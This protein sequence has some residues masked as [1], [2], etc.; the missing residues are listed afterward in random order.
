MK[1]II[2]CDSFKGTLSSNEANLII[3]DAV[4]S[5]LEN[6]KI[7]TIPYSD[8]GEGFLDSIKSVYPT[9]KTIRVNV[10]GSYLEEKNVEY[11]IHDG[12]AFIEIAKVCG[13]YN[14]KVDTNPLYTTTFG[15][16]EVILDALNKGINDFHIGLGGSNT[17]DAGLGMIAALGVRFINNSNIDIIPTGKD[18]IDI[19]SID[20][21]NLININ[22]DFHIYSDVN[23]QL[24]GPNG[25]TYCFAKQKGASIDDLPLLENGKKNI[26]KIISKILNK[27]YSS[28]KGA[29]AAGGLGY[30]FMTFLNSKMHSGAKGILDLYHFE[31]LLNDVDYVITGEGKIDSTSFSGKAISEVINT[32]NQMNVPVILVGGYIT[33]DG[34]RLAEANGVKHLISVEDRDNISID[35]LRNNAKSNLYNKI[36]DFFE[37]IKGDIK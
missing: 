30:S 14:S 34:M 37:N 21:S 18:L 13:L 4:C 24:L 19:K 32:A 35:E 23:N 6:P 9:S 29:G 22:A 3:S 31:G 36:S 33:Q 16:G 26:V 20:A 7:V 10:H 2:I 1:I 12:S 8:G 25:A 11:L 15:I 27:D 28:F 17:D 5:K